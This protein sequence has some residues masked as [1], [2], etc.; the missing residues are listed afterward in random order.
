LEIVKS[1]NDVSSAGVAT[2]A[3]AGTPSAMPAAMAPPEAS[4]VRRERRADMRVSVILDMDIPFFMTFS[5]PALKFR[6]KQPAAWFDRSVCGANAFA[7][8]D[9]LQELAGARIAG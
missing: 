3:M 2:A 5:L 8:E 7:L 1:L 4:I 6:Q 9:R